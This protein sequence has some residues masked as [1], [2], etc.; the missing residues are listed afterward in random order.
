[1]PWHPKID[2][3]EL[4]RKNDEL[5]FRLLRVREQLESSERR[6]VGLEIV[7]NARLTRIGE[8][9]GKFERLREQNRRLDQEAER[10]AEMVRLAPPIDAATPV[11]E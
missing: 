4:K 7:L 11:P 5:A 3:L 2:A 6:R 9:S 1:M 8:L 10:L